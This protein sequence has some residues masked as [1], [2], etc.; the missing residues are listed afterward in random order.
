[1]DE[2]LK[3]VSGSKDV[4]PTLGNLRDVAFGNG[5]FEH[6]NNLSV[7][8]AEADEYYPVQLLCRVKETDVLDKGH[9]VFVIKKS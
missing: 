1:M 2:N 8:D 6:T 7:Y 4:P 3:I 5:I 9:L